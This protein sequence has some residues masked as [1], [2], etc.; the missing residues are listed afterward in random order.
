MLRNKG[1]TRRQKG[2]KRKLQ[3]PKCTA[4]P[5]DTSVVDA[6]DVVVGLVVVMVTA[7]ESRRVVESG[8]DDGGQLKACNIG[9]Q[10]IGVSNNGA[11]Q[12]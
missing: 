3:E 11:R 2:E 1:T 7:A 4:G 5:Y 12:T 9:M 10:S 6:A 8:L